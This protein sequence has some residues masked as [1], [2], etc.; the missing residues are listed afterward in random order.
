MCERLTVRYWFE[1]DL[2]IVASSDLRA[3][4][5]ECCVVASCQSQACLLASGLMVLNVSNTL[6]LKQD[7]AVAIGPL[8]ETMALS[9][10]GNVLARLGDALEVVLQFVDEPAHL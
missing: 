4:R 3:E 5:Q 1:Q 7:P 9:M 6:Y 10:D 2:E 8:Q